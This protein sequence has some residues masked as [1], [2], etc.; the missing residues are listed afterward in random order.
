MDRD[1]SIVDPV[2]EEPARPDRQSG[3]WIRYR[4]EFRNRVTK[5]VLASRETE[6]PSMPEI[7]NEGTEEPVFE[8]VTTY[9]T[10]LLE[11]GRP[12]ETA[13]TNAGKPDGAPRLATTPLTKPRYSLNIFSRTIANALQSVV[14]YY[15]SQSLTADPIAVDWPYP[16]LVHHYDE[17]AA[18]RN[19]AAA[20]DAKDLCLME[21]DADNHISLL[22]RF[23]DEHVMRGVRAELERNKRG[24]CTWEYAW[25]QYKPGRTYLEKSLGQNDWSAS[26]HHSIGGG[27]FEYPPEPWVLTEWSMVYNGEYLGRQLLQKYQEKYDGAQELV[28]YVVDP[29]DNIDDDNLT[30]L[31]EPVQEH[32][33]YGKQYFELLRKQCKQHKG[34]SRDFPHNRVSNYQSSSSS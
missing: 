5:E 16:V 25:L 13:A 29:I 7:T 8:L 3:A 26:V 12:S 32:I 21:R 24:R 1:G 4:T 18:F 31:P 34:M 19:A 20:K 14:N 11:S 15:P 28:Q 30:N 17:L 10:R 22:L 6:T 27:I 2:G 23:L 9:Y 33:G